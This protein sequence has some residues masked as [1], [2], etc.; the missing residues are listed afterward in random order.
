MTRTTVPVSVAP[1]DIR[2]RPR[3]T[4]RAQTRV[5]GDVLLRTRVMVPRSRSAPTGAVPACRPRRLAALPFARPQQTLLE[6]PRRLRPL[7]RT[8]AVA[9]DVGCGGVTVRTVDVH[10]QR[11]QGTT[12]AKGAVR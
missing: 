11:G 6:R 12:S 5:L 7:H 8:A 9:P 3:T 4:R 2:D 10:G 1:A